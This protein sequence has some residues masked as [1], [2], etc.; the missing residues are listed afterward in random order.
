MKTTLFHGKRIDNGAWVEGYFAFLYGKEARIYELEY[1]NT[2][3]YDIVIPETVGLFTGQTDKN[4]VRIFGGDLIKYFGKILL[5]ELDII[6]G[7]SLKTFNVPFKYDFEYDAPS[8]IYQQNDIE[9]IG[10]M[11]DKK[12]LLSK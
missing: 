2:A 3:P 10:N 8:I 12:D 9:V 5:V 6:N 7:L 11:H 1:V 4:G